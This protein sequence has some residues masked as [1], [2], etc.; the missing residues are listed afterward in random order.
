MIYLD[1]AVV[2]KLVHAEQDSPA[3]RA[4]LDERKAGGRAAA[5]LM[6]TIAPTGG[7]DDGP[8]AR[9]AHVHSSI[10]AVRCWPQRHA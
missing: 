2:V 6:G 10:P 7:P 3:L 4:W 1:S 5:D 8:G 9:G